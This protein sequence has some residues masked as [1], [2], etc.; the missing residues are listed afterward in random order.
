M[1]TLQCLVVSREGHAPSDLY[2]GRLLVY[3]ESY[4]STGSVT[5]TALLE[6]TFCLVCNQVAQQEIGIVDWGA[7]QS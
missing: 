5:L 3:S 1:R 7:H 2:A 4:K 6:I